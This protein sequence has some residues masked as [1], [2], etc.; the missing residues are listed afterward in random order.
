MFNK[1]RDAYIVW[2]TG[3]KF[4]FAQW[5]TMVCASTIS[6]VFGGWM[7]WQ[8]WVVVVTYHILWSLMI[9]RQEKIDKAPL[10]IEDLAFY[11]GCFGG[12]SLVGLWIF[13]TINPV[14][15]M[16]MFL[17]AVCLVGFWFT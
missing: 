4:R 9:W 3:S 5:I 2:V 12:I 16:I 14:V 10:T 13:G 1:A 7:T 15:G 6:L 11:Y 17:G 8:V